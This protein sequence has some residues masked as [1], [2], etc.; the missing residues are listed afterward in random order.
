MLVLN[1]IPDGSEVLFR[2]HEVMAPEPVMVG[3]RGR[4]E[5]AV[6]FVSV[7]FSGEYETVGTL[8]ITS[9]VM[10]VVFTPPLFLAVIVYVVL[11]DNSVGVPEISPVPVLKFSPAGR[12]GLIE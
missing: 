12:F 9:I 10:V 2:A 1:E 7:K 6:L 3:A 8:S 4:L 5:L 11:V